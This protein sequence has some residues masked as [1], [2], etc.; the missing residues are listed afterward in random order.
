MNK[1]PSAE[2]LSPSDQINPSEPFLIADSTTTPAT[3][4]ATAAAAH[5]DDIALAKLSEKVLDPE[6]PQH[7]PNAN[8]LMVPD[9]A[10]EPPQFVDWSLATLVPLF[11]GL[12]AAHFL[13]ALDA[14][15][16]ATALTQ[17][18]V[19]LNAISQVSW[20]AT[21]YV[22]TFNAFQPLVGKFSQ[23]FGHRVM[24][25]LGVL[26]FA[27]GSAGCGA[28]PTFTVLVIFRAIQG[29]GGAAILAMTIITISDMFP[30]EKRAKYLTVLW[31]NFG[32]S[33]IVGP[34]IGGA[35]VDKVSWRWSFYINVPVAVVAFPLVYFFLKMP[36]KPVPFREQIRRIDF[37]GTF[38][39][40]ISVICILIP[41]SL[42]GIE[43]PWNSPLIITCFVLAAIFISAFIY[44][45]LKLAK[46]PIIPPHLFLIRNVVLIF[47]ANFF[48]G[49]CFFV[50]VFY[51]PTYF[52]I[53][54]GY[55]ATESG[56]QL[57]PLLLGLVVFSIVGTILLPVV[58]AYQPYLVVGNL[59]I[60]GGC[61]WFS[62]L[63]ESS[64]RAFE[65]VALLVVGIGLGLSIQMAILTAQASCTQKDTGVVSALAGFFQS[66]G[67]GIG[68]AILSALFN[69]A[70][71]E[72]FENL[73]ENVLKS[74]ETLQNQAAA[75]NGTSSHSGSSLGPDQLHKLPAELM[76]PLIGVYLV[77]LQ[78][79]FRY[80]APFGGVAFLASCFL[81]KTRIL[82]AEEM[83]KNTPAH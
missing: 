65:I 74:L 3:A 61:I 35:F 37:L 72:G 80:A 77:G 34:L 46:E 14:T 57:L 9:S 67:G 25:L 51:G 79:I 62:F 69:Q 56:L 13:A 20:I 60:T 17:I 64:P 59:M 45:Q 49:S 38:L 1:T 22:L 58:K 18:G 29:I 68:L 50:F 30:I 21:S 83:A 75:A 47:I 40:I 63:N 71:K 31:I 53:L 43:L 8:D 4:T 33:T 27:I 19:E 16:V 5:Q 39:L 10:D 32:I 70:I 81:R 23:I 7:S 12:V 55:S 41:T 82:S 54:K 66:I 15:I 26:I 48:Q 11:V 42:G 44:S 28:A 36:F 6:Q 76:G 52:Q 24:T 2:T 73:P 78:R